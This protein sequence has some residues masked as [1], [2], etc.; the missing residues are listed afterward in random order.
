[1]AHHDLDNTLNCSFLE[2]PSGL[3]QPSPSWSS[4]ASFSSFD[5]MDEGPVYCVPHEG[6]YPSAWAL[7]L[8]RER[9]QLNYLCAPRA[10]QHW[11]EELV[12]LF[13]GSGLVAEAA[14]QTSVLPSTRLWQGLGKKP[15]A[16]V[17]FLGDWAERRFWAQGGSGRGDRKWGSSGCGGA[18]AP[19]DLA[20]RSQDR[21]FLAGLLA[22]LLP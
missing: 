19:K 17:H 10:R 22:S 12:T 21:A 2:P 8:P 5:T 18:L 9:L 20:H 14:E 6:E 3:E 16:Q 4:R 1:M 7:L 13:L 15:T 11:E